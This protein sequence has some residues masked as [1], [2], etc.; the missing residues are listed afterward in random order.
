MSNINKILNDALENGLLNESNFIDTAKDYVKDIPGKVGDAYSSV[1]DA[2]TDN[3]VDKVGNVVKYRKLD[4][5]ILD[6]LKRQYNLVVNPTEEK[7]KT[8]L[9]AAGLSA[10]A[11]GAGLGAVALAKKLRAKKAQAVKKDKK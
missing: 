6:K 10:A 2:V 1:K 5:N 3:V 4:P 7:V 8:G 9:T 11:L